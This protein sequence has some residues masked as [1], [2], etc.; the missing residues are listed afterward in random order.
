MSMAANACYIPQQVPLLTDSFIYKNPPPSFREVA[1]EVSRAFFQDSIP[2]ADLYT[3]IAEAFSFSV[4]VFPIDPRTYILELTHGEGGS[5]TDFGARFAARLI[6]YFYR[7]NSSPPHILFTGGELET[8][9]FAKALSECEHIHATVLYPKNGFQKIV[10]RQLLSLPQNIHIF[11]VEGSLTDCKAM[12][13]EAAADR[14]INRSMELFM[15]DSAYVANLLSYTC[16]CIYAALAV[17]SRVGYDNRIEKP[18]LIIGVP[19]RLQNG[20]CAAVLAKRMKAPIAGFITTTDVSCRDPKIVYAE[21]CIRLKKLCEY[22]EDGGAA[23]DIALC[24][25]SKHDALEAIRVCNE[26]TGAII[27]PNAGE[28]WQAWNSIKNGL[29]DSVDSNMIEGF[30]VD[31]SEPPCWLSDAAAVRSCI[32]IMMEPAHPV[33]HT[34]SVKAATGREPSFPYRFECSLQTIQEPVAMRPSTQDLK[35][36]LFSIA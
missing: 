10:E 4:P 9:S 27:S 17:L 1:F 14:D 15:L 35:D 23:S 12:V 30:C 29:S 20:I 31:G 22:G 13:R 19:L 18:R 6:S 11:E 21:E 36:W 25:L 24:K 34:E 8:L 2:E 3:L 5:Y 16:C 33:Y 28:I 7:G 26:R 32:T